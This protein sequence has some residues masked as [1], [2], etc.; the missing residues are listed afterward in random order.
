[1]ELI[2]VSFISKEVNNAEHEYMNITS[3]P[4]YR[5]S[6]S[7]QFGIK[8]LSGLLRQKKL[9]PRPLTWLTR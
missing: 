4:I 7:M 5:F 8:V 1:M 2:F 9:L 3:P 6:E